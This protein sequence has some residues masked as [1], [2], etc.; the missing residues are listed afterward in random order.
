MDILA[1]MIWTNYGAR[2]INKKLKEKNKETLKVGWTMAWSIFPDILAFGVPAF[3]AFIEMIFSGNFSI[4]TFMNEHN[5]FGGTFVSWSPMLYSIGHSIVIWF[6]V[7]GLVWLVRGKPFIMLYG[8]LFHI[9]I[10]IFSHSITHYPTPFLFPLSN[11][12]FPYGV[13]WR[14]TNF[15]IINYS[16][17]V[18]V[19]VYI[20]IK[21]K[22]AK[23]KIVS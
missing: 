16:L 2:P 6:I 23:K 10:D 17:I 22:K 3:L 9:C 18:I 15:I 13:S 1:H 14:D 21:N 4:L 5:I 12:H 20:F 7:F 8:W 19:G 11:Y